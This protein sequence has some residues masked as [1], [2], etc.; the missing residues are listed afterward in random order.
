ME[1]SSG[2][3]LVVRRPPVTKF[4][5]AYAKITMDKD[6]IA[7][8]GVYF[9]GLGDSMSEAETLARDCV[10]NVRG[11]TILPKV[12]KIDGKEQVLE[13]LYDASDKFE[14]VTANMQEADAV[15]SRTQNRSRK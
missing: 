8:Q 4:V 13:A 15:I 6:G 7:L 2:G 12:V 9:G 14:E 11:G 1:L 3:V 10:N 5:V